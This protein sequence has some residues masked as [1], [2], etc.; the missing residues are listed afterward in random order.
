MIVTE[1]SRH[2][3]K[4][5]TFLYAFTEPGR[6]RETWRFEHQS[7]SEVSECGLIPEMLFKITSRQYVDYVHDAAYIVEKKKAELVCNC[8]YNGYKVHQ[9]DCSEFKQEGSK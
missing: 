2:V 7:F 4:D 9:K 6:A 3:P 8:F 5:A 1:L